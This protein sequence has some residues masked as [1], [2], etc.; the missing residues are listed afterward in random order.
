M[1]WMDESKKTT[2]NNKLNEK[3]VSKVDDF[4]IMANGI[5]CKMIDTIQYIALLTEHAAKKKSHVRSIA[6][7]PILSN[8][9]VINMNQTLIGT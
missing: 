9:K 8:Q 5:D 2:S 6:Q 7:R 1:E 4:H 3:S